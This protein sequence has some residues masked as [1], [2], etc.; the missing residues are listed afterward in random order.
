[1]KK[2]S[3]YKVLITA[4]CLYEIVTFLTL[5]THD[6][7]DLWLFPCGLQYIILCVTVPVITT[8]LW[9]WKKDI[10]KKDILIQKWSAYIIISLMFVTLGIYLLARPSILHFSNNS[11]CDILQKG[12]EKSCVMYEQKYGSLKYN[13]ESKNDPYN[14]DIETKCFSL[15]YRVK[16]EVCGNVLTKKQFNKIFTQI[17]ESLATYPNYFSLSCE[18]IA[19]REY[20]AILSNFSRANGK[21]EGWQRCVPDMVAYEIKTHRITY[22]SDEAIN[23][24]LYFIRKKAEK[25]CDE[26]KNLKNWFYNHSDFC[27]TNPLLNEP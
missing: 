9:V 5:Y 8:L 2:Q 4:C 19:E 17:K 12:L 25:Y 14:Y 23:Q 15:S 26:Q 6:F 27:K 3:D 18:K 21:P 1:M 7:C 11:T 24:D 16:S 10:L 20:S 22:S 13:H